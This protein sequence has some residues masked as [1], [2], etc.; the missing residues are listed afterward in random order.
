M[1][2]DKGRIDP[3]NYNITMAAVPLLQ[4]LFRRLRERPLLRNSRA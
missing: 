2:G 1:A 4:E 3:L